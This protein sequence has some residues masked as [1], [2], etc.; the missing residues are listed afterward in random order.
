VTQVKLESGQRQQSR[1]NGTGRDPH[2]G[3]EVAMRMELAL[4]CPG[5]FQSGNLR[6]ESVNCQK[7][8]GT[9]PLAREP[10]RQR[11]QIKRVC[12][13]SSCCEKSDTGSLV[14]GT[15]QDGS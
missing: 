1:K 12:W 13:I 8:I 9:T 2:L 3:Y 4:R 6:R 14:S 7:F 5:S 11:A 10:Y 15:S